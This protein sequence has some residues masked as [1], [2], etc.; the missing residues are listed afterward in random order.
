M[1]DPI[2]IEGFQYLQRHPTNKTPHKQV[3]NLLLSIF[4]KHEIQ[5]KAQDENLI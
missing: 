4:Y 1:I 3:H 2:F 5:K